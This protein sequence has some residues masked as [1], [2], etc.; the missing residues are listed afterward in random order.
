MAANWEDENGAKKTA[1]F[2]VLGTESSEFVL[3]A[4]L[5]FVVKGVEFRLQKVDILKL[6]E[7]LVPPFTM[8]QL[9]YAGVERNHGFENSVAGCNDY[10]RTEDGSAGLLT[11]SAEILQLLDDIELGGAQQPDESLLFPAS[12]LEA[13]VVCRVDQFNN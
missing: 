7:S 6:Q 5:S 13:K 1:S 4:L 9:L 3:K 8:P 2:L 11:D 10:T 12:H